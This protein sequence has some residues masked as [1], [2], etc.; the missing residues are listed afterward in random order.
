M[1]KN[2]NKYN[3]NQLAFIAEYNE[4]VDALL[5]GDVDTVLG[6]KVVDLKGEAERYE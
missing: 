1:N 4:M 3:R 6:L 2:F 5:D